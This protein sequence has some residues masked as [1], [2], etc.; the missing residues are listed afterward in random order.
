LSPLKSEA[1][2]IATL[3]EPDEEHDIGG[4]WGEPERDGRAPYKV[5]YRA[6]IYSR[7]SDKADVR[8]MVF[9]EGR[10]RYCVSGKY[11]GRPAAA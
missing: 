5:P 4:A 7:L 11:K 9:T 1:E 2:V 6:F 8:F 10:I 3:G